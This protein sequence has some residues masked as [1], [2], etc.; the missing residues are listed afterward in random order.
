MSEENNNLA[1]E[2]TNEYRAQRLA[3]LM[4]LEELG[5][6]PFGAAFDRTGDVATIRALWTYPIEA[7]TPEKPHAEGPAEPIAVKAA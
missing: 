1:T 2:N 7:A 3:N 6:N 4:A 5:Y